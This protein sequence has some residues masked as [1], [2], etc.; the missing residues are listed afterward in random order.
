[1]SQSVIDSLAQRFNHIPGVSVAARNELVAVVIDNRHAQAEILLQGAQ[2]VA[3]APRDQEP[4]IWNSPQASFRKGASSRGGIPICWPWFGD[5][6]RNPDSVRAQLVGDGLSAHGFVR[7][8]DWQLDAIVTDDDGATNV[9]LSLAVDAK[10]QSS[11]PYKTHLVVKHH[12]GKTLTTEFIIENCDNRVFNFSAALHTYFAIS[13]IDAARID[14]FAGTSYIDAL[15]D[16]KIKKQS[17]TIVIDREV[18]R[19]YIDTPARS[20]IRDSGWQREVIVDAHGS[21]S[22][23]VW[24]PW[25]EKSKRLSDFAPDAYKDM[26]CIE[27]ANVV[28]DVVELAPGERH[29]LGVTL[30]TRSVV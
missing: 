30:S 15:D 2:L 24:N 14:G 16:W 7:S 19:I 21:R 11:W 28:G 13:A 20:I 4:V 18:D 5:A 1:M 17:D 23:V 9:A 26:L 12:I 6:A 22:A 8:L 3:F 29:V 25:I 27:T 10:L